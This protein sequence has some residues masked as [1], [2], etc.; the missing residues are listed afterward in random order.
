MFPISNGVNKIYSQFISESPVKVARGVKLSRF[1]TMKVGGPADLLV[2][3]K[4]KEELVEAL[5]LAH[6]LDI[7]YFVLAGGSNV[8]FPDWTS[9]D[10]ER[11]VEVEAGMMLGVMVQQLLKQ[12]WGGFNFLANIPGSVGGAIVG[13]AGCYGKEIKDVLEEVEIFNVKT[14][15]IMQVK[16]S[17]LGFDYRHSKLKHQPE[18]IVLSAILKVIKVNSKAALKE[19]AEEKQVR[20]D[21]HPQSPS[22]GSWF[23]NPARGIPAWKFIDQAGLRGHTIGGARISNKHSNFL[24]NCGG[25]KTRDIVRL[26]DLVKTRVQRA[27]G[28]KLQEEAKLVK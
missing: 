10:D 18:L 21:K 23:K 25:A 22:C 9:Q 7:P 3:A 24:V 1:C 14:G 8:V 12:N 17:E 20:L 4:T 11:V 6:K 28:I 2:E 27:T 13:N 16:P 15:K 19:I 5:K 26:V